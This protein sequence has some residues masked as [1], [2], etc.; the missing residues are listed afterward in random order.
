MQ[1][2]KERFFRMSRIF[3]VMLVV[4]LA[5]GSAVAGA[6]EKA[7][8]ATTDYTSGVLGVASGDS[9]VKVG[10]AGGDPALFSFEKDGAWKVLHRETNNYGAALDTVTVYNPENWGTPEVNRTL[11]HN[12]SG[13]ATWGTW[14]F[15]ANYYNDGTAS[16][17]TKHDMTNNYAQVASVNFDD[18]VAANLSEYVKSVLVVNDALFVLIERRDASWP[19]VHAEG[20]LVKLDPASLEEIGRVSVGKNPSAMAYAPTLGKILVTSFGGAKNASGTTAIEAV[21]VTTLEKSIFATAADLPA[22][23]AA[24]AF[25]LIG[26]TSS[27]VLYVTAYYNGA[28]TWPDPNPCKVFSSP[29]EAL[30]FTQRA[31]LPGWINWAAADPEQN[32]F[33][34]VHHGTGTGDGSLRV[35]GGDGAEV[36]RLGETVLGGQPYAVA[37]LRTASGG[38]SGG[39]GGCAVSGTGV[40]ALFLLVPLLLGAAWRR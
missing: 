26:V 34:I 21:S 23:A 10:S 20:S 17:L 2:N 13:V 4:F 27:G 16:Y 6:V 35:Y 25:D 11:G 24:Y 7:V 12:I 18:G 9:A 5:F 28:V 30:A 29:V 32:L 3:T 40:G 8:Y 33:W 19:P 37:P 36:R 14:L 39:G 31:S 15:L 1:R 38:D 22:D